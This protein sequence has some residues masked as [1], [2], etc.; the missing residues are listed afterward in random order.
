MQKV[1]ILV[2]GEVISEI[3][4]MEFFNY[5]LFE[6]SQEM[7]DKYGARTEGVMNPKIDSVLSYVKNES[8]KQMMQDKNNNCE[9]TFFI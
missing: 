5:H 4:P 6:P 2:E 1:N 3:I 9:V 7:Q 8:I